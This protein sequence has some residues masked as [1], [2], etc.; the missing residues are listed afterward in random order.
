MKHSIKTDRKEN[1][2]IY[3]AFYKDRLGKKME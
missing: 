3:E 2:M 1:G